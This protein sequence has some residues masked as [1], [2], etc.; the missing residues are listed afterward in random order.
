VNPV[1]QIIKD[2]APPLAVA[3]MRRLRAS[4]RPRRPEEA[5][6]PT[7]CEAVTPV[8]GHHGD[9]ARWEDAVAAAGGYDAQNILDIQ[10]AAMRKVR[11]GEAAYERD[12]VLFDEVVLFHPMLSALLYAASR[13]NNGLSVLDYGGALGSSY[14]QNRT[15]LSHLSPLR[16]HVVEQLHFVVAGNAEFRNAE[17]DFFPNLD[18]AWQASTPN[19]VLLSSVLQYVPNA[20]DLLR[21]ISARRPRFVLIDRTPV[22]EAGPDCITVQ[23]VPTSIYSASYAAR[24]LG[25]ATVPAALESDYRLRFAFQAS[26]GGPIAARGIHAHHRGYFYERRD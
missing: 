18:A 14:F 24:L 19:L 20:L 22:L 17:L 1:R 11:D 15:M 26:V 7:Q 6:P 13:N 9:Y 8:S 3:A 2:L 16:W 23:T 10:R 12:S 25:P 4:L 21:D 5:L